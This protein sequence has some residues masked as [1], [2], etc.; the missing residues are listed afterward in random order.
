MAAGRWISQAEGGE[1]VGEAAEIEA[2]VKIDCQQR[3]KWAG[4][5]FKLLLGTEGWASARDLRDK[6][7]PV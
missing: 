4:E 1:R 2:L 6:G 7:P 3:K 5:L